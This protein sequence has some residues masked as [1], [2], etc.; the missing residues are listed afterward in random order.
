MIA[1]RQ[2][3]H[4]DQS[5][6]G[7]KHVVVKQLTK[8]DIAVKTYLKT[9]CLLAIIEM[10]KNHFKPTLELKES[11][12]DEPLHKS[13]SVQYTSHQSITEFQS[14][15]ASIITD[16]TITDINQSLHHHR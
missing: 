12:Q 13:D 15:L 7:I 5:D 8:D 14:V 16:Q 2:K 9:A 11:I 10:P 4:Y 6:S 1:T 3:N